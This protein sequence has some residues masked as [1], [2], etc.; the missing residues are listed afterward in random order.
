MAEKA[1][2]ATSIYFTAPVDGEG[3]YSVPAIPVGSRFAL[4]VTLNN[5]TERREFEISEAK[6]TAAAD[7]VLKTAP[8]E[9]KKE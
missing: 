1:G 4:S 5:A 8:P 9:L 2:P 3:R 7:I 6:E